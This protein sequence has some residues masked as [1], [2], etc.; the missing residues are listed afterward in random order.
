MVEPNPLFSNHWWTNSILFRAK[1]LFSLHMKNT[2]Y[3]GSKNSFSLHLYIICINF[4]NNSLSFTCFGSFVFCA[5]LYRCTSGWL[6][7]FE[8]LDIFHLLLKNKLVR[9]V[10]SKSQVNVIFTT[11]KYALDQRSCI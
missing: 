7:L 11:K 10:S 6:L 3:M 4:S 1:T 8:N 2:K 5:K 9:Y